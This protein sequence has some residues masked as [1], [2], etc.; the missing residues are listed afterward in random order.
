MFEEELISNNDI[1][2]SFFIDLRGLE[3]VIVLEESKESSISENMGFGKSN[4]VDYYE[5]LSI[6][7][8][9]GILWDSNENDDIFGI[10]NSVFSEYKYTD[11][12]MSSIWDDIK[13]KI[14]KRR[15]ILSYDLWSNY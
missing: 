11:S 8:P 12:Q 3:S 4:Y 13:E 7:L 5:A 2:D 14:I 10:Y 1:H 15:R 6:K 9:T